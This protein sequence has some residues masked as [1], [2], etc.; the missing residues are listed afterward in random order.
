MDESII[1]P[2]T[3]GILGLGWKTLEK[4]VLRSRSMTFPR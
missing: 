4:A 2:T 1:K 3:R